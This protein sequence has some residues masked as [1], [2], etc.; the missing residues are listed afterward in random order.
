[1]QKSQESW[2]GSL[3]LP[4]ADPDQKFL[5]NSQETWSSPRIQ[6]ENMIS[7][8]SRFYWELF[9]Y[10]NF[11]KPR[12]VAEI[13][14]ECMA[15]LAHWSAWKFLSSSLFLTG[16]VTLAIYLGVNKTH[17]ASWHFLL[18]FFYFFESYNS[19]SQIESMGIFFTKEISNQKKL[20]NSNMFVNPTKLCFTKAAIW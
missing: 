2:A 13:S 14:D 10:L 4:K 17:S 7:F 6:N 20:L 11:I 9:K 19:R 16:I 12:A 8:G 18:D 15:F 5:L 3:I 1:M